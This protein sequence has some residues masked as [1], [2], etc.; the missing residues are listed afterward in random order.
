MSTMTTRTRGIS[1]ANARTP[2][3]GA[4]DEIR[5]LNLHLLHQTTG[6]L[7]YMDA[8]N[9]GISAPGHDSITL[10]GWTGHDITNPDQPVE[11]VVALEADSQVFTP[12]TASWPVALEIRNN[13]HG[14]TA[15]LVPVYDFDG[16]TWT[17]V[18]A[19]MAGGNYATGDSRFTDLISRRLGHY[20]YG[21]VS[22][23][24]RIE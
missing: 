16:H 19:T 3:R 15:A 11:H 5:G 22:I 10:V 12:S 17:K 21:A 1:Q 4:F 24:D 9:G 20:F 18:P 13:Y 14:I 7:A 23:H 8:T 6:P 2:L